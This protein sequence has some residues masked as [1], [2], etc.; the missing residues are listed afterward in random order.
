MLFLRNYKQFLQHQAT[1]EIQ[2]HHHLILGNYKDNTHHLVNRYDQITYGIHQFNKLIN[3][4][5]NPFMGYEFL[6]EEA[7][8]SYQDFED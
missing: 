4:D 5:Q 2:I 3:F 8:I 6:Q 1:N 7:R